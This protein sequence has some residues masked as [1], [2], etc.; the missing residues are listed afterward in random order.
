MLNHHPPAGAVVEHGEP[1]RVQGMRVNYDFFDTL[2]IRPQLGRTFL[3]ERTQTL[4]ESY[5]FDPSGVANH[6]RWPSLSRTPY[7]RW[8]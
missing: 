4:Q 7:S 8:P 3:P 2:G 5:P 6:H 1:E